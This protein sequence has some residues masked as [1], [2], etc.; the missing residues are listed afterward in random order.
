MSLVSDDHPAYLVITNLA[1]IKRGEHVKQ[2][3]SNKPKAVRVYNDTES[4]VFESIGEAARF[5][6]SKTNY[7]C[8]IVNTVSRRKGYKV[9]KI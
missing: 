2:N 7:I 3:T 5:L 4:H 1:Q 8:R 6:E 9:E